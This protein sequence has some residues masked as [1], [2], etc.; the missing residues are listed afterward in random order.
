MATFNPKPIQAKLVEAMSAP[1]PLYEATRQ[2]PAD[3]DFS[4]LKFF[5]YNGELYMRVIPAKSLFRSS[6]IHEVV[7]RGNIFAVR[8][9][10]GYLTIVP[11]NAT[12]EHLEI[13]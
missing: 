3:L 1:N 5:R 8:M 7:N 2:L 6:M 9:S 11:G 10:T 12:V 13:A 4:A